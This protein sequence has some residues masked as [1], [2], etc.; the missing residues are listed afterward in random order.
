MK[1]IVYTII[2]LCILSAAA[3][4]EKLV[5]GYVHAEEGSAD[6]ARVTLENQRNGDRCSARVG[7]I[8]EE[9]DGYMVDIDSCMSWE[10]GD[11][12]LIE[13]KKGKLSRSDTM[14]LCLCG[15]QQAPTITLEE[16]EAAGVSGGKNPT[17]RLSIQQAGSRHSSSPGPYCEFNPL[18]LRFLKDGSIVSHVQVNITVFPGR[19]RVS[20]LY[21][22]DST[23]VTLYFNETGTYRVRMV[24]PS[25]PDGAYQDI[26]VIDCGFREICF[27]GIKDFIEWNTDCGGRCPPCAQ[28]TTTTTTTSTTTSSTTTTS[29]S[30]TI[31][32][33]TTIHSTTTTS[34][35]QPP[36][37]E[38]TTT[39]IQQP[40]GIT[41]NILL[42]GGGVG[43]PL[44]TP[45]NILTAG[46]VVTILFLSFI[47]TRVRG[48]APTKAIHSIGKSRMAAVMTSDF[49][50]RLVADDVLA[51]RES[52]GWVSVTEDARKTF[53]DINKRESVLS[54]I[55]NVEKPRKNKIKD[56]SLALA[57][58]EG[59]VLMTEDESLMR[60]AAKIGVK[61]IRYDGW[62]KT[63]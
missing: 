25:F 29:S 1:T 40:I 30:T 21:S 31:P 32:A 46:G 7:E 44:I 14:T 35:L 34:L 47:M 39:S 11:E 5:Y 57:K 41:G 23:H 15:S 59:A 42:M 48:F 60:E 2:L 13:A 16:E 56:S 17:L 18:T 38:E 20:D 12:L 8:P 50:R 36:V 62:V 9:P 43:V 49:M 55:F 53:E 6:G 37:V 27:N 28:K 63:R 45:K 22:G 61:T 52:Y 58:E 3:S 51:L 10:P 19:D 33:A 24:A 26:E 4:A 54:D